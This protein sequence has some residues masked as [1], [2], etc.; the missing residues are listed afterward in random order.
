MKTLLGAVHPRRN[1]LTFAAAEAFAQ[2]AKHRGAEVEWADLVSEGFD[3]GMTPKDE[4]DWANPHKEYSAA[5]RAE[6]GATRTKRGN[7]DVLSRLVVVR[8]SCP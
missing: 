4:P 8:A 1:S 6:K 5:V 7:G 3:P 2:A